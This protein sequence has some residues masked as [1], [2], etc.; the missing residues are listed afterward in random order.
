LLGFRAGE[1]KR[2][3]AHQS[4]AIFLNGQSSPR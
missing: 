4:R 1:R 2:C 3:Y